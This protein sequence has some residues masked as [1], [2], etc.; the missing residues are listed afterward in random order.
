MLHS[1]RRGATTV[2]QFPSISDAERTDTEQQTA[3]RD[4][5]L[6]PLTPH[7]PTSVI[8]FGDAIDV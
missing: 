8:A 5:F 4:R 6:G 1:T 3:G 2:F 7:S